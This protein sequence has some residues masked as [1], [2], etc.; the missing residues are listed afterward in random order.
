MLFLLGSCV[1][2]GH[3]FIRKHDLDT[4]KVRIL[5]SKY[6]LYGM[7]N[8]DFLFLEGCKYRKD[9]HEF[10]EEL[11][12]R[13]LARDVTIMSEELAIDKYKKD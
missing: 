6:S 1:Q 12:S 13:M 10:E 8:I 5:Y 3:N 9:L 4:K 11:K 7:D 2:D